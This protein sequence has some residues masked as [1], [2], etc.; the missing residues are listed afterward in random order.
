MG[1]SD[2]SLRSGRK[3]GVFSNRG[4]FRDQNWLLS[5]V[6]SK[7]RRFLIFHRSAIR[8]SRWLENAAP[9]C[10]GKLSIRKMEVAE[11]K[12]VRGNSNIFWRLEARSLRL[13][14][15]RSTATQIGSGEAAGLFHFGPS[16][17]RISGHPC[18]MAFENWVRVVAPPASGS[19][20]TQRGWPPSGELGVRRDIGQW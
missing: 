18:G 9:T 2:P 12:R 14:G 5:F 10:R 17:V 7:L 15:L 4:N 11:G 8:I 20:A 13:D 16:C 3:P 1:P 19:P 6:F